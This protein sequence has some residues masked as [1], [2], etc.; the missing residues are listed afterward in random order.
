MRKSAQCYISFTEAKADVTNDNIKIIIDSYVYIFVCI[1]IWMNL[2]RQNAEEQQQQ[3]TNQQ[4]K[5][6]NV[7]AYICS[8]NREKRI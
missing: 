1:C 4:T 5:K 6:T 8:L 2:K 7:L 3:Q